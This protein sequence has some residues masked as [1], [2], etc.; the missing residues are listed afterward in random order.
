MH[1]LTLPGAL[2]GLRYLFVPDFAALLSPR[3]RSCFSIIDI[4]YSIIN[5][6]NEVQKYQCFCLIRSSNR[7]PTD[8][9]NAQVWSAAASQAFY[10]LSLCSGNNLIMASYNR[11]RHRLYRDTLLCCAIDTLTSVLAGAVVF[12][13]LGFMAELKRV[14]ID[15]VAVDGPQILTYAQYQGN[16]L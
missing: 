5:N 1:G 8:S 6:V 9:P 15:L 16:V 12:A 7:L 13:V 14:P 11:F 3:V 10:S 2:T 4:R